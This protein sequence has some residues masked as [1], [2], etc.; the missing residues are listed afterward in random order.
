MRRLSIAT[1]CSP[2]SNLDLGTL[3]IF[4]AIVETGSFVSGG[5]SLGLTRSAAG[6]AMARLESH[7]GT[8]LLHRT[9]RIVSMTV[10]GERFY[11]RCVQIL[12][13]LEEAESSIRQDFPQPKGTLRLTVTEAYGRIVVLPFL[14]KFLAE[15][16]ELDVEVS[17]TDRVVDLI[18]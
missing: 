14:R 10:D 18:K 4:V 8:R 15:W 11:E 3:R 7:L 9:T 5:K 12:Q 13:D 16:P 1:P 17:F 2:N 6:K